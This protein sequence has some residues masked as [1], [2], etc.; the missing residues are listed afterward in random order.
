MSKISKPHSLPKQRLAFKCGLAKAKREGRSDKARARLGVSVHR[1]VARSLSKRSASH[2]TKRRNEKMADLEK[3]R[4]AGKE[5][6]TGP[7]RVYIAF[8]EGDTKH[9][10]FAQVKKLK[11]QG[12]DLEAMVYDMV[13]AKV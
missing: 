1:N 7:R 2:M 9:P 12:Y 5:A 3:Y 13:L 10:G 11:S 4:K 8:T 6:G